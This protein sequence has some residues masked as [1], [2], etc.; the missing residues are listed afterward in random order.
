MTTSSR[1]CCG[2]RAGVV[3]G[4]LRGDAEAGVGGDADDGGDLGGGAGEG[5][6]GRALVDGDVP[7]Q[8][9]GVV[10]GVAGQVDAA[11]EQ[12]AQRVGS[13][14]GGVGLGVDLDGHEGGSFVGGSIGGMTM[15]TGYL[16]STLIR[17]GARRARRSL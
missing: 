8:A 4:A 17:L 10:P 1:P 13:G 6:G 14:D 2:E 16:E 12:S 15:P 5:D 3:A 7:G 11:V 9:G